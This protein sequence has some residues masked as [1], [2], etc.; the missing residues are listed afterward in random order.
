MK[1]T[2]ITESLISPK[3]AGNKELI[4]QK[5]SEYVNKAINVSGLKSFRHNIEETKDGEF[6]CEIFFDAGYNA[7]RDAKNNRPDI[8]LTTYG[9]GVNLKAECTNTDYKDKENKEKNIPNLTYLSKWTKK[10]VDAIY[11]IH[12]DEVDLD[13]LTELWNDFVEENEKLKWGEQRHLSKRFI[14]NMYIF[15]LENNLQKIIHAPSEYLTATTA[16]SWFAELADYWNVELDG[17]DE[18]DAYCESKKPQFDKSK[19][20]AELKESIKLIN[21]KIEELENALN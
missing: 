17:L 13:G 3:D 15:Y 21:Q 10:I 20:I 12:D 6:K 16:K 19:V 7:R 14:E 8:T 18:L 4:R 5:L 1:V 11:A 9:N 2:T